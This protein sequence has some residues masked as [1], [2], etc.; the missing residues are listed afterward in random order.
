MSDT[1]QIRDHKN[2]NTIVPAPLGIEPNMNCTGTSPDRPSNGAGTMVLWFLWSLINPGP[3][4]NLTLNLLHR[5]SLGLILGKD[6]PYSFLQFFPNVGQPR[7]LD[8]YYINLALP[9]PCACRDDL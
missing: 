1:S 6:K 8:T 3:N 2:H 7:P 5:A 4:P 9:R